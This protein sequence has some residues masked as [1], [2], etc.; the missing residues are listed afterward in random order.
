MNE[1]KQVNQKNY[2]DI[3]QKLQER[4]NDRKDPALE[5]T[6]AALELLDRPDESYKVVVVGGTN[7][8][9]STVEMISELLQSQGFEVGTFKSPHLVSLRERVKVDG[10][11]IPRK[12]FLELYR[13]INRLDLGLSF[14]EF[15]TV[16][17][18]TYF[19]N[20][21]VDY[22]VMEVGMG[23]RLDATNAA[24]NQTA[25][26]TNIGKDHTKYLGNSLDQIA[27]EIAGIIPENGCLITSSENKVLEETAQ[28]NSA[29]ILRPRKV[30]KQGEKFVFRE[31]RFEIPL[32]GGFQTGNL[33][34]ALKTVEKLE[35]LPSSVG[36]ALSSLQNKGR[37]EKISERPEIIFDGA[38][39]VPA[40]EKTIEEFPKDFICVF[41]AVN[42]KNIG[43]MIE[44]LE[45]KV[46]KFYLTDAGVEWAESPEEIAEHVSKPFE[47]FEDSSDAYKSAKKE[48]NDNG[49]VV[50]TGS[51]YL[52][53]NLKKQL[54]N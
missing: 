10:E 11:K 25:V 31:E 5:N 53:G 23:G 15:M 46:S 38:H 49:T 30:E 6:E 32:K 54:K 22:A 28:E 21:N 45:R 13:R 40:L 47:V 42:T 7:G 18:Y 29:E 9:G 33:E 24:N 36:T 2:R 52:I 35:G 50:V 14:F 39:N 44:I 27:G 19:D 3:I 48:V 12:E 41:A 26:I 51:L 37:M 16:L 20:Q 1:A 17:A 43:E 4:G 34:N 8:K